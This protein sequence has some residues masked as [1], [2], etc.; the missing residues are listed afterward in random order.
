MHFILIYQLNQFIT[1]TTTL[2]WAQVK[3]RGVWICSVCCS[4]FLFFQYWLFG[5]LKLCVAQELVVPWCVCIRLE[6]FCCMNIFWSVAEHS[7]ILPVLSTS[8]CQVYNCIIQ[9]NCVCWG[10]SWGRLHCAYHMH[11]VIMAVVEAFCS[12]AVVFCAMLW[13]RQLGILWLL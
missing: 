9:M 11:R 6:P 10:F 3:L 1:H 7:V 13:I 4:F 5:S 8:S 2:Y 12:W